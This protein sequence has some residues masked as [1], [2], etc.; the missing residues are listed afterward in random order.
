MLGV[1]SALHCNLCPAE[2]EITQYL[3]TNSVN[4]QPQKLTL[5]PQICL[6]EIPF[7]RNN[8]AFIHVLSRLVD[9]ETEI[10][11]V[12]VGRRWVEVRKHK[13]ICYAWLEQFRRNHMHHTFLLTFEACLASLGLSLSEWLEIMSKTYCSNSVLLLLCY[14][15][16]WLV[17]NPVDWKCLNTKKKKL[18]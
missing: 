15:Y 8:D 13:G 6:N 11:A 17:R 5:I 2:R 10:C 3:Q 4:L 1:Y 9:L 12:D 14:E 7:I 16:L 18:N